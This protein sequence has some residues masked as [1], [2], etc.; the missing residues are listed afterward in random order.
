MRTCTARLS[1]RTRASACVLAGLGRCPAPC[2]HRIS[3]PEYRQRA[4]EP[5][6]SAALADPGP[7]VSTLLER[8]ERLA[9]DQRFEDAAAART[10]MAT[11][12]RVCVRM[13]RLASF[14]AVAQVVAARPGADGWELAVVRHGRLAGAALAPADGISARRVLDATLATAETVLPG[15]GPVPAADAAETERILAWLE[16]PETRLVRISDSWA[17]P[18]VSAGRWRTFL[19][20]IDAGTRHSNR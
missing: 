4:C 16:R 14:T 20:R 2:E 8:L 18:A 6:R 19:A 1:T 3:V 17:S 12:L 7:L 11:L 15:A 10:R 13:Q 9:A 5:F